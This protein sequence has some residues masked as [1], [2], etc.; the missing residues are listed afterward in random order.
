MRGGK[1]APD[2]VQRCLA[3]GDDGHL[4]RVAAVGN[5]VETRDQ[6]GELGEVV[7]RLH[8]E[9]QVIESAELDAAQ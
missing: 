1:V 5:F 8:L 2:Q 9:L 6:G 7:A 4:R 3:V